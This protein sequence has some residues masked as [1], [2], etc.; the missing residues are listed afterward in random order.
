MR[1]AWNVGT[2]LIASTSAHI[3]PADG[4]IHEDMMSVAIDRVHLGAH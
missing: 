4:E 3:E 1:N 2:R